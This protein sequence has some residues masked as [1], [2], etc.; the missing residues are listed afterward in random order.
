MR[1][2]SFTILLTAG[3]ILGP[4]LAAATG[5][6]GDSS[7]STTTSATTTTSSATT[8]AGGTGGQGGAGGSGTTT[9]SG[10]GGQGGAG[11]S[12]P[13]CLDASAIADLFTIAQG[14]LCA[15]AK[16]EADELI[17]QSFQVPSWGAHHGPL[18][19]RPGDMGSVD[20]VRWTPPNGATGALGK[21]VVHVDAQIPADAF[22]GSSAV[23]LP[24]FGWTAIDW[25]GAFPNTLGEVILIKGSSVA[26]RYDANG[27]FALGGLLS[28]PDAGRLLLTGL[29]PID[30]TKAGM[31][32]LYAADTCGGAAM[33]ALIP[34]Q[35]ASCKAP[36]AVA[37]WGDASGPVTVDH[38][39]NAFAVMSS[40]SGDQ[41]GRGF[42]AAEIGHNAGA[43]EGTKLFTLG[44][45]G[46]GLAALAP[47][48]GPMGL[49]AFQPVDGMTF[50][51]L[52]VISVEYTVT[53]GKLTVESG[54]TQLLKP[55]V[56]GTTLGL[57]TDDQERLWV[58][59][60]TANGTTFVVLARKP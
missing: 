58:A 53:S 14:S 11:G 56:E 26:T 28:A 44:G 29:S 60:P 3:A 24:F 8:T 10:T 7:T 1:R 19:V 16:Y 15:V 12:G 46:S 27:A 9:T 52:D 35:D 6:G 38:D 32:G 47:S 21:S 34:G 43:A 48:S 17:V 2:A 20:L 51:A 37:T 33:P 55:A 50:K 25:S 39:G 40:F 45:F 54:P 22:V 57:L 41:E 13:A 36:I 18:T 49:L 4:A 31:N 5:C 42:A 23:D 30:E 59:V